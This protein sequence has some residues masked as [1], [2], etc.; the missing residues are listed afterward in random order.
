MKKGTLQEM[1]KDGNNKLIL[2][3]LREK[4]CSRAEIAQVTGL[5]RSTVTTLTKELISQGQIQEVGTEAAPVGRSPILLD[6]VPDYRYMM[7]ILFHRKEIA[8]CVSDLRM[9]CLETRTLPIDRVESAQQAAKWAFDNGRQIF[10]SHDIPWDR[11]A[12]IGINSPGPLNSKTGE[13]LNPPEF[14]LFHGFN[15]AEFLSGLCDLPITVSNS[16]VLMA[17]TETQRHRSRENFL[18][19]VVDRGVGAAIVQD[20]RVYRGVNGLA[21][22]F[23]HMSIDPNGEP[24]ACGN[25]GCLE[26]YISHSALSARFGMESY[27]DTADRACDGDPKALAVLDHV[28]GCLATAIAN[29]VN[30]LDLDLVLM[31]GELNHR[32][33]F[34]FPRIQ[35]QVRQRILRPDTFPLR[36][37]PSDVTK[38]GD[39]SYITAIA[40]QNYFQP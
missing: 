14:T 40:L 8:V 25:R 31:A 5:A 12:G 7:G 21:G 1:V 19:V 30:L 38:D 11:C 18:F 39:I 13:I 16:P 2:R 33:E 17:V 27:R 24:C 15:P 26:K 10:E 36:I 4:P 23:G 6:L 34:L 29:A 3:Q 32:S 35:E 20:G 9:Q 37:L 28:A 22:E